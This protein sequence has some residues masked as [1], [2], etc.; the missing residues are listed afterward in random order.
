M[1]L[2]PQWLAFDN[3]RFNLQS[4]ELL[5]V[6]NEGPTTAIPLGSRSADLLA[7]F[8]QRPGDLLTKSEI[9]DA[10]WPNAAMEE[11]NLTVQVSALRRAIDTGRG[12]ASSIQTV[13]GRGYRFTL[14][15]TSLDVFER[16]GAPLGDGVHVAVRPPEIMQRSAEL[17]DGGERELKHIAAPI[18]APEL[19]PGTQV[20]VP[21]K[22]EAAEQ[23]IAAPR[24][25]WLIAVMAASVAALAV[26][27]A[28]Y[29]V[30]M[31]PGGPVAPAIAINLTGAWLADDG[32]TYTILQSGGNVSWEGVSGDNG[33]AWTHTFNGVIRDDVIVGKYFD[34]PPGK[35]N[36]SGDLM[37][38]VVDGNRMEKVMASG[39]FRGRTWIRTAS[40]SAQ[41]AVGN[42]S[43]GVMAL[44][45][46]RER[47]LAPKDSF[48]ECD[49]CPDMVVVPAGSFTM[50]SPANEEGRQSNESPQHAV[51]V[52][53][54]FAVGR[55]ALT[56]DEWDACA[57]DGG[58]DG[59]RP[60]DQGWGRGRRPV[61]NVSWNDAKAYLA[62]LSRK[63]GRTYRL[64]SEAER[65]YVA[66]AGATT[67]FW[68]GSS[69]STSQANYDGTLTYGGGV[70]DENR[71]HTL[72]VD[73]F[74]PNPW[75]LYQVHGNVWDWIEDCYHASYS[76]AP[77]DDSAWTF[78]DCSL[79]VVRGGSWLNGPRF[80][81][82]AHRGANAPDYRY[83][84]L[85]FRVARTL[86]P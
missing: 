68:W 36:Y 49:A 40:S 9:M 71:Q 80:L 22:T 52:A 1:H 26:A 73:K 17:T 25:S 2:S 24:R 7:L 4:R 55:F 47:T 79:R 45:P 74:E 19:T 48:K 76:G 58:C 75:A 29:L 63:T 83:S 54:Q 34:H 27:A 33:Q 5:R 41:L 28:L 39:P 43:G 78:E 82:A 81:R 86:N 12:G 59:Y 21:S 61:I 57:A 64:L 44:S 32:G 6:S 13:A 18:H 23:L 35:S 37:I 30:D 8:V 85:G 60:A 16:D 14:P 20:R 66:R 69:I 51:T 62:W 72:P 3:F 53:R 70:K 11:S 67:P 10:V 56:F 38:R 50:G 84:N 42:T 77:A 15:V 65:E 31:R 46:E